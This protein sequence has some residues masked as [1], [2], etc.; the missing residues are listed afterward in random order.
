MAGIVLQ[1]KKSTIPFTS[2]AADEGQPMS[3][4]TDIISQNKIIINEFD[5]DYQK[6][7]GRLDHI[8]NP[9]D[10]YTKTHSELFGEQYD[11]KPPLI[12]DLLY[13]G[14]Y[15]LAG[16]PK[17]GKSFLAAQLCYH[18]STGQNLWNY[19]VRQGT[20]LYLALE[21]DYRRLQHR[22]YRMFG[23]GCTDKLHF[24]TAAKQIGNGLE[25]QLEMFVRDYPDTVLVIID[26]LQK[27]RGADGEKYSYANDY[28]VVG[29]LK[30]IADRY[31]ICVVLI[32]HTRKQQ[33]NDVFELISGTTGLLG[34]ADG[35]MVLQK[36]RG[37][38]LRATLDI[39]GRDQG[40][41]K[42]HLLRD[43]EHLYWMLDRVE[44]EPYEEPTDPLLETINKT[45][46]STWMGTATDLV[47]LLD[48]DMQPNM[49]SR[50]L[51]V[52]VSRLAVEYGINYRTSRNHD[53]RKILLERNQ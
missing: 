48:L 22:M 44:A 51:N 34:C 6:V 41:S 12:D 19:A 53:G 28:D 3:G 47:D 52:N 49:L 45:V 32:H 8:Y 37:P 10:L 27:I 50:Y 42:L 13:P 43:T 21:D 46:I 1:N 33:S 9:D 26:T 11:T 36:D 4:D 40:E 29:K 7:L 39:V 5:A 20:V 24:T 14:L 23:L 16:A 30:A 38:T 25:K 18:V 35:A 31:N 2:V 17:T 15:L